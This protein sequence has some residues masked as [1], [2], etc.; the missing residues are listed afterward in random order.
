M[1]R[2]IFELLFHG[3]LTIHH[4]EKKM[5]FSI[6]VCLS[7]KKKSEIQ[8]QLRKIVDYLFSS[9]ENNIKT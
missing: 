4:F 7:E 1:E 5:S 8:V 2:W 6:S 9:V 3:S